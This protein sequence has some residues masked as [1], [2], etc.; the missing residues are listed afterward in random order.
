MSKQ[1]KYDLPVVSADGT[2][3]LLL[4]ANFR[5]YSTLPSGGGIV[6]VE[7]YAVRKAFVNR[8][9]IGT[10]SDLRP[11]SYLVKETN[12][13]DVGGG[14]FEFERHYSPIP[15]SWYDYQVVN[16][17]IDYFLFIT[18]INSRDPSPNDQG[19]QVL[20][21]ATRTYHLESELA[22]LSINIEAPALN[23]PV[24]NAVIAPDGLTIHLGKIYEL[25]TYRASVG[26]F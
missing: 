18:T 12:Y 20:A 17:R 7:K 14:W 24:T 4:D 22:D 13:Q 21:K 15:E 9:A 26:G 6:F 3:E 8:Q 5:N 23:P 10:E 2:E 1:P 16:Y 19:R 11:G 25:I